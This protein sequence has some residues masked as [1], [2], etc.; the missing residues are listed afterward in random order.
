MS[1][2]WIALRR[3]GVERPCRGTVLA[4]AIRDPELDRLDLVCAIERVAV[5][6]TLTAAA[7][8]PLARVA[9]PDL[10][11]ADYRLADAVSIPALRALRKDPATRGIPVF[12]IC[13]PEEEEI[14]G[15]LLDAGC[16]D[17]LPRA[18]KAGEI[19]D[20]LR[21]WMPRRR[22]AANASAPPR[23]RSERARTPPRPR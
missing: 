3:E 8:L 22:A 2:P 6:R 21:A 11:L 17:V 19:L 5:L 4:A 16:R 9:R 10:I 13:D 1:M 7:V 12:G 15:E 14:R 23:A 18:F 20:L